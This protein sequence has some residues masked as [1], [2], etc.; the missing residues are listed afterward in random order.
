[1]LAWWFFYGS[2]IQPLRDSRP[3]TTMIY[4]HVA[5][6]DLMQISSPLDTTV[7][8]LT[9][10]RKASQEVLISQNIKG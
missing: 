2:T 7:E 9:N 5:H 6:R 3:E 10:A 4:T 8:A 1:M